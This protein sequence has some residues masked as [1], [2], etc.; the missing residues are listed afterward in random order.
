MLLDR[1]GASLK[2]FAPQLQTTF[3]KSLSDPSRAVRQRS[4][5]GLG[6]LMGLV[7]RV[8]PLLTELSASCAAAEGNAIK[9]ST[10]EVHCFFAC[11]YSWLQSYVFNRLNSNVSPV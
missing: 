10:L 3:V 2:A 6:K 9:A 5:V 11:I 4:A 1:G 7:T 8:D